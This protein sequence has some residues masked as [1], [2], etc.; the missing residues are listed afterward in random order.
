MVSTYFSDTYANNEYD[1]CRGLVTLGHDVTLFTSDLLPPRF[2]KNNRA[3]ILEKEREIE[4]FRLIRVPAMFEAVENPYLPG[5]KSRIL[6]DRFDVIHAQEYYTFNSWHAYMASKSLCVP[7]VFTQHRHYFPAGFWK[8]PFAFCDKIISQQVLGI[9]KEAAG[10]TA[11][12][13]AAKKF[14]VENCGVREEKIEIIPHGVSSDKY[15]PEIPGDV[16]RKELGLTNEPVVLVVGR[17]TYDKGIDSALAMLASIIGEV[18]D[19]KLIVVGRGQDE[20]EFRDMAKRLSIED[21]VYFVTEYMPNEKMPYIYAACDL[22][23]LPTRK[24]VLS[25]ANLEAMSSGKPVIVS[26]IGGMSDAV[27]HG[28][29]GFLIKP[30]DQKALDNYAIELLSDG[31][32]RQRFGK[33]SREIIE[34]RFSWISVAKRTA[35]VYERC[36]EER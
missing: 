13:R 35:N 30:D 29:S 28:E 19:A 25:I 5:L 4:G 15:H 26:D 20:M 33:Q 31:K 3:H 23:V 34:D 18:P 2:Y 14:L 6:L 11:I 36:L 10:I 27:K 9:V 16:F 12:S 24:E 17:L 32:L 1:L 7:F 22:F 8:L 21:S